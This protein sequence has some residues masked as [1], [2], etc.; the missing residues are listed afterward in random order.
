MKARTS[1]VI[2]A[3]RIA[4]RRPQQRAAKP[5]RAADK[6]A[7]RAVEGENRGVET[8]TEVKIE[9]TRAAARGGEQEGRC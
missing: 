8:T 7:K 1:E 5:K 2:K 6:K 9:V 4:K 3:A